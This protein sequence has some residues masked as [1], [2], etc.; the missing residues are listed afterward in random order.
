M[1]KFRKSSARKLEIM[2]ETSSSV[3]DPGKVVVSVEVISVK[4]GV[5]TLLAKTHTAIA[6]ALGPSLAGDP[7]C[8]VQVRVPDQNNLLKANAISHLRCGLCHR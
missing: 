6:I 3:D 8:A 1:R 5:P 7:L 2:S 4:L